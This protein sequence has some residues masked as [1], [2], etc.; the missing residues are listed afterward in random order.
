M[1]QPPTVQSISYSVEITSTHR[2]I[3]NDN[4]VPAPENIQVGDSESLLEWTLEQV[5]TT[6]Q[7]SGGKLHLTI[8]DLRDDGYGTRRFRL[9]ESQNVA[10]E[11]LRA[12]ARHDYRQSTQIGNGR[13]PASTPPPAA[14]AEP[15]PSSAPT[16]AQPGAVPRTGDEKNVARP[17]VTPATYAEH[18]VEPSQPPAP[19]QE[20]YAQEDV[21]Q[22]EDH[23]EP[24]HPE[25]SVVAPPLTPEDEVAQQATLR[26]APEHQYP[27]E[28]SDDPGR[29][30][31]PQPDVGL[32]ALFGGRT[33]TSSPL[34]KKQEPKE[35]R[36]SKTKASGVAEQRGEDALVEQMP[37]HSSWKPFQ[38]RVP[39]PAHSTAGETNR[40]EVK[41]SE[42]S[43]WKTA[44]IVVGVL[45]VVFVA[46][47]VFAGNTD[48]YVAVCVDTRTMARLT[49]DKNCEDGGSAYY[50]WWYTPAGSEVPAVEATVDPSQGVLMKPDGDTT[51]DYGFAV[52]GGVASE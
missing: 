6:H 14:E 37:R 32:G 36:L 47:R 2:L 25:A 16:T 30:P 10:I 41:D 31:R 50:R 17:H 34:S 33:E 35:G 49:T 28:P 4:E 8:R 27:N 11:D 42:K 45:A 22:G 12:H 19:P 52:D 21:D 29:A 7:S 13:Q 18:P 23:A 46:L 9:G 26:E 43:H 1:T 44:A 5:A 48:N 24:V 51:I 39:R 3:V 38:R 15:H 20:H 40:S